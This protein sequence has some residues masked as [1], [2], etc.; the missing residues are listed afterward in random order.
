MIEKLAKLESIQRVFKSK[1]NLFEIYN[2]L[3]N[4]YIIFIMIYIIKM[5]TF[6]IGHVQN[7]NITSTN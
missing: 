5:K 1:I 7:S 2:E 6:N 4:L 3:L